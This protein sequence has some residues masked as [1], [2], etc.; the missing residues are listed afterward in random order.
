M[1]CDDAFLVLMM[2]KDAAHPYFAAWI[3]SPELLS[4]FRAK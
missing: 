3:D 4:P 1:V 2:R